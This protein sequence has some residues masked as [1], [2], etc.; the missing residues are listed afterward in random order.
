MPLR[1][2]DASLQSN[3]TS[4]LYMTPVTSVTYIPPLSPP[5]SSAMVWEKPHQNGTKFN[6]ILTSIKN[7]TTLNVGY[8]TIVPYTLVS[9]TPS[10]SPSS[11]NLRQ[12]ISSPGV[13]YTLVPNTPSPPSSSLNVGHQ[14][15]A[16]DIIH[17]KLTPIILLKDQ[18]RVD[19]EIYHSSKRRKL[20]A[21]TYEEIYQDIID[22]RPVDLE[23]FDIDDLS[24][25]IP[26][27]VYDIDS[28]Y[29]NHHFGDFHSQEWASTKGP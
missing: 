23:D 17:Q 1:I 2:Y 6:S 7:F 13:P 4:A 20:S 11:L 27:R 19:Q 22:G 9:A 18:T 28:P 24:R 3:T 15:S 14:V 21:D 8:V 5:S 26:P 25:K 10:P 29:L 16:P 12:Q